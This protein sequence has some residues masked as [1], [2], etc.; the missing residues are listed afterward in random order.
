[1]AD[2]PPSR[3]RLGEIFNQ[4]ETRLG[5]RFNQSENTLGERF[6]QSESRLGERFNQSETFIF[7]SALPLHSLQE[8]C[9]LEQNVP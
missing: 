8:K 7:V 4:S 2:A 9:E 5:E 1:M 3:S 6:N